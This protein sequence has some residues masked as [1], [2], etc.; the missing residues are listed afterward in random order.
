MKAADRQLGNIHIWAC[1]CFIASHM[2][3]K[4]HMESKPFWTWYHLRANSLIR[5]VL[6]GC[7]PEG[8]LQSKCIILGLHIAVLL[9]SK[10]SFGWRL[11]SLWGRGCSVSGVGYTIFLQ[12][13]SKER[14][15]ESVVIKHERKSKASLCAEGSLQPCSRQNLI[16][17]ATWWLS[18]VRLLGQEAESQKRSQDAH[19][20]I[21]RPLFDDAVCSGWISM[22]TA[23]V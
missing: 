1:W 22:A 16:Q 8:K 18:P 17:I 3:Y 12:Q 19:V 4:F 15:L 9:I 11:T 6:F 13:K 10:I 14:E 7:F 20:V 21:K 2:P 23:L 5:S